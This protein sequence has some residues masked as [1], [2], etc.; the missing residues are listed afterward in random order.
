MIVFVDANYFLRL[1]ENDI[2]NQVSIV[3]ELFEKGL[4]GKI[5]L[6]SSVIVAFEVY[7]VLKSTYH[8]ER[9]NLQFALKKIVEIEFV[10]WENSKV[11]IQAINKMDKHNYD[12]EDAY[13]LEYAKYIE[14]D[15]MASFDR[16]L[17]KLWKNKQ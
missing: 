3:K 16:K 8:E 15:E 13:N 10:D 2:V 14:A 1:I 11:L 12:L 9:D 7:W 6:V 4:E 17:I 5:K